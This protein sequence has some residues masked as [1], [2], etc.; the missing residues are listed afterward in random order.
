MLVDHGVDLFLYL[1]LLDHGLDNP[2]GPSKAAQIIRRIA[3]RNAISVTWNE[4]SGWFELLG[5]FQ[6]L[7]REGV[8]CLVVLSSALWY[9]VQQRGAPPR[10]RE[11]CG[12]LRPH[13]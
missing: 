8:A 2:I 12:D 11:M 7:G 13:H 9:Y 5:S 6:S 10:I 1:F 3:D 4:E